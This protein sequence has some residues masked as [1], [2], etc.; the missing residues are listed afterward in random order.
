[1]TT[2]PKLPELL[3][4]QRLQ[5]QSICLLKL[6]VERPE[7]DPLGEWT[8]ELNYKAKG[9]HD[10]PTVTALVEMSL[11]ARPAEAAGDATSFR[12]AS[13]FRIVYLLAPGP[14]VGDDEAQR[15][16]DTNGVFN[17][18]PYFREL[19]QSTLARCGLPAVLLPLAR[20]GELA[21]HGTAP[22]TTT[23]RRRRTAAPAKS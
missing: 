11:T 5:I 18:W 10:G 20:I 4:I 2:K 22:P 21:I 9:R 1:M 23:P 12:I 16:A 7:S 15:V 13:T 3:T 6:D 17:A 14:Q 19:L 8:L